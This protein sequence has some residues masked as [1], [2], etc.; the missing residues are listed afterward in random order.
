MWTYQSNHRRR[1]LLSISCFS[2]SGVTDLTD[3][4]NQKDISFSISVAIV[5][6][7]VSESFFAYL[8]GGQDNVI[9]NVQSGYSIYGRHIL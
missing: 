4:A 5:T 9:D 6:F 7:K 2:K 1:S 3:L 8:S